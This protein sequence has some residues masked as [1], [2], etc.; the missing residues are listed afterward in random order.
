VE[1]ARDHWTRIVERGLTMW[2][3]NGRVRKD[4]EALSRFNIFV[5]TELLA[6][7]R[8]ERARW[9]RML[10]GFARLGPRRWRRY[11]RDSRIR[12]RGTARA[13]VGLA[14]RR[15]RRHVRVPGPPELAKR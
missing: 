3:E 9:G 10:G 2:S 6:F 4:V 11:L 14:E 1:E 5:N 12:Q 13:R 15:V 8:G 7:T